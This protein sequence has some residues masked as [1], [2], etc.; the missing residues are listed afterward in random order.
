MNN[1]FSHLR[2]IAIQH[3]GNQLYGNKPYS[4]HLD[5]VYDIAVEFGLDDNYLMAAYLHDMIEDCGVDKHFIQSIS[6]L[7]VAEMVFAVSGEGN[8]R[9]ERKIS[10]ISKIEKFFKAIDLKM[11]DRL[12]NMRESQI[13]NPK[14]FDMYVKELPDY[15]HLFEKG[16]QQL[17]SA[18][19]QFLEPSKKI[20]P[21]FH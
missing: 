11:I 7:E 8:N 3:H 4:Y 13:N 9:K 6:N 19:H 15:L 1:K 16:N 2:T 14:L 21:S 20:K 18:L 17:Y 12:A 10:M 5:M